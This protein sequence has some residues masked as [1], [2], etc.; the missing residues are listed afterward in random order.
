MKWGIIASV[1]IAVLATFAGTGHALPDKPQVTIETSMG[2]I[3]L[4]LYPDDAPKT[5]ANFLNYARW[6]HYDG[7]IFHRVIP[8]FMIQ[9]GGF[10]PKMK[11]KLT[12]M[13]IE[14]EADNGL[15]NERGTVAMARTQDPH[16]A[17]AQF[18]INTKNNTFLNHK[19]KTAEGWGYT[20]FGKVTKGMDVV[21][22]ISKVETT[23]RGSMAN[24]PVEPV[25]ITRV[26]V[27]D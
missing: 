1:L 24:V 11:E 20:V 27:K 16:S 12:E 14:N 23:T 22:A 18:F 10:T 19:S 3:V 15:K 4:D 8:D 25:V 17:T 5:V 13:S 21:D 6:G 9:G 7:T 2:T 26:S